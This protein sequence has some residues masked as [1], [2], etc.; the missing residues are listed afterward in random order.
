VQPFAIAGCLAFGICLFC[1]IEISPKMKKI[2]FSLLL[3]A[4]ASV[5]SAQ[6][7]TCI[8]HKQHQQLIRHDPAAAAEQK[9]IE[10]EFREYLKKVDLNTLKANRQ[11]MGKAA[12]KYIIPVVFH[13]LHNSQQEY[14][15]ADIRQEIQNMNDCYNLRNPFRSRVRD[16]FKDV[17][18]DAQ[19]EF[20][21]ATKDPQ[22]NCTNGIDNIYVGTLVNKANDA[23]KLNSWDPQRYL[24][25]WTASQIQNGGSF[26]TGGYAYFPT[27]SPSAKVEGLILANKVGVKPSQASTPFALVTGAHE[28][29]HYL[30]LE[31]PF[32]NS[33]LDSC[34]D[35][36]GIEDTPPTYLIPT[37]ASISQRNC[38]NPNVN[39]CA[40]DNPDMP[41]Q[42]ENFMDYYQGPCASI[43][44][45][46]RQ[47]ARMHF[48]LE[49]YRRTLWSPENLVRTGVADGTPL[50]T[51]APRA[52]F[53]VN[54]SASLSG[55]VACVNTPVNLI[56]NSYNGTVDSRTWDFG[57]DANPAT[58]TGTSVNVKWSTPGMKTVSLTVSNAQGS[59]TKTVTNFINILPDVAPR[60]RDD[61][62]F[63]DWDYKNNY[64][65][66][67]WYFENEFPTSAWMRTTQ[68]K[69]DGVASLKFNATSPGLINVFNYSL[70]SPTFDFSGSNSNAYLRFYYSWAPN[71]RSFPSNPNVD[72]QDGLSVSVSTDCGKSWL[73]KAYLGGNASSIKAVNP[74]RQRGTTTFTERVSSGSDFVPVNQSQWNLYEV[75]GGLI[76]AQSSVKFKITYHYALG[77]NLYLDNLQ[78]GYRVGTEEL[79]AEDFAFKVYPNPFSSTASLTYRMP[80]SGHVDVSLYDIVGRE[81]GQVYSGNQTMGQHELTV[82]RHDF[83]LGSGIYF[84]KFKLGNME[85]MQKVVIN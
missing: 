66:E 6:Q 16:I 25:V 11:V 57:P 1:P 65:E 4:G 55:Y 40:T 49:A 59:N 70:I 7:H 27:S 76:P 15:E 29:G 22:G 62:Q 21:L 17:E 67:G 56:D 5:A 12:P 34:G 60:V 32:S 18:A 31:H 61:Q 74:L 68:A 42:Y 24:N 79:T 64:L 8:V 50:V 43:M 47:V 69:Y 33:D 58:A 39:T 72:S 13:I 84:L 3:A 9:R 52:N 77:N 35:G 23:L 38:I 81:V 83:N 73:T 46:L 82:N 54:N 63:A 75:S 20:R 10:M 45:T 44:F 78:I 14:D 30:G 26:G 85:M 48:T 28:A 37:D 53:S 41:D 36:D 80:V 2:V 19:I 51:C 71:F